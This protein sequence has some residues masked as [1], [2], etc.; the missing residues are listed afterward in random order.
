MVFF[1]DIL[2]PLF[3]IRLI[4]RQVLSAPDIKTE[5]LSLKSERIFF[6]SRNYSGGQGAFLSGCCDKGCLH[7][8][9]AET[10]GFRKRI[11]TSDYNSWP[12]RHDG[13][14]AVVKKLLQFQAIRNYKANG[15]IFA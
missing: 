14:R 7:Q 13:K 5:G 3:Y 6:Y 9:R 1:L 10:K 15:I 2:L 4:L 8:R 11:H 12:T